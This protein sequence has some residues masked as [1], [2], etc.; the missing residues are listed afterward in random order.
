MSG[1]NVGGGGTVLSSSSHPSSPPVCREPLWCP[2]WP[3]CCLT[4]LNGKL[5]TPLTPNTSWMLKGSLWG[6]MHSYHSLQ[7]NWGQ[8][9]APGLKWWGWTLTPCRC[10]HF[11]RKTCVFRRRAGEDGAVPVFRQLVS[12]VSVFHCGWSWAEH[13]GNYRSHT[14]AIPL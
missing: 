3:P 2:T 7:V 10:L 1:G 14:H 11:S 8:N 6:G 9:A 12:E 4:R 13:R 5:R